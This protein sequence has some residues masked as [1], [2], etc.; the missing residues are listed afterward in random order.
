MSK[1]FEVTT[2]ETLN[3]LL[4]EDSE[5]DAFLVIRKLCMGGINPVW[6]RVHTRKALRHQLSTRDWDVIIADYNVPGLDAPDALQILKQSQLDLPFIVISGFIGEQLAVEMMQAGAHDYLMKENL[7]RLTEAVRREVREAKVRAQQKKDT[8]IIKQ[9]LTAIEAAIDGI[10]IVQKEAYL[11]VNPSFLRLFGYSHTEELIGEAWQVLYSP[12]DGERFRQEVFPLLER[13][14]AWEGEA[15]GKRKDGS[16][17]VQGISLTLAEDNLMIC[18]CRDISDIKKAQEIISHNALHDPLTNLPNRELFIDRLTLAINRNIRNEAYQYAVLF[19]DLDR[20]KSI[21]DSLGHSFGDQFLI[22]IAK[23]L[24]RHVRS[25]DLVARLGGDEFVILL[26][27]IS[28]TDDIVHVVER[29][30]EN[31]QSPFNIEGHTVFASLSIGIALGKKDY[32]E[33]ADLLRDSDIAMYQAKQKTQNS[34]QF[35]DPTIHTQ[36]QSKFNL[37][38]DFRNALKKQQFILHYQP[39]FNL[40]EHRI[41]GFEALVRWQHPT[42]GLILPDEFIPLAEETGLIIILDCWVL[43]TACQQLALWRQK[44]S[45]FSDLTMNINLSAEDLRWN[46]L[47]KEIDHALSYS[48]LEGASIILEITESMLIKDIDQTINILSQL[49]SRNIKVSIDDFGTGYSSLNYLHR[50]PVDS[51][52]IDR[53]FIQTFQQGNSNSQIVSTIIALSNQLNLSTV[54]EGIEMPQQLQEL[55]KLGCKLGQGYLFSKPLNS[56]DIETQFGVVPELSLWC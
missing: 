8:V 39:I 13:D 27:E 12:E 38:I 56:Q 37:E 40:A 34:Y 6:E 21:N 18:V 29:I 28:G 23:L 26:E 50:L 1:A 46:S 4:I 52:K 9:Q 41:V 49:E 30:F 11:Y 54:A 44:F 31:C 5:G 47:I 55:K 32:H 3:V 17:F 16:S 42:H 35:F 7:T 24:E 20:F 19:I 25:V 48:K 53:S 36:I 14:L 51:L 10:A 33:A 22:E 15:I 43:K 2:E 45:N